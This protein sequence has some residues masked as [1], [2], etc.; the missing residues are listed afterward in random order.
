[1]HADELVVLVVLL[2]WFIPGSWSLAFPGI[3]PPQGR[4]EAGGVSFFSSF[5][6]PTIPV[7]DGIRH[8]HTPEHLENLT[9]PWSE[10]SRKAPNFFHIDKVDQ[11]QRYGDRVSVRL[12]CS[13]KGC[14][15]NNQTLYL[16]S[17][18][19]TPAHCSYMCV[20]DGRQRALVDLR[21]SPLGQGEGH[22]LSIVCTYLIAPRA[23][24]RDM[25]PVMRF[26]K[27]F[28]RRM[29]AQGRDGM[30]YLLRPR[31]NLMWYRRITL[32]LTGGDGMSL[33]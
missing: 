8:I 11:P 6:Y 3:P 16:M 21:V 12:H 26:L 15:P 29:H 20:R 25:E 17:S 7:R 30:P 9:W 14:S 13:V 31:A 24:D 19:R 2:L 27:F 22:R 1:M 23:M 18:T 32:G 28:E 10:K 33:N 4:L 5:R